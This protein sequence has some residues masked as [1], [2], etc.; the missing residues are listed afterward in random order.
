MLKALRNL[1]NI[2]LLIAAIGILA[3]VFLRHSETVQ[4]TKIPLDH[5]FLRATKRDLVAY[6]LP[7]QATQKPYSSENLATYTRLPDE[8]VIWLEVRPR[9]DGTLVAAFEEREAADAPLFKDVLTEL[10]RSPSRRLI[11]NFRGNR[12]GM[13]QAFAKVVD[14]LRAGDRVLIQS[15]EDGFLKDLR[16]ARP[17]WIYGTSLAQVTRMILFSS[18]GLVSLAQLRGDVLVM[19][20][21]PKEHLL[22]RIEDAII[23]EAHRRKLKIFAGPASTPAEAIQ[24][25]KRGIDG[26]LTTQ[27]EAVLSGRPVE[28][29]AEN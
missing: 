16:E 29:S 9:L 6:R 8:V 19:E 4:E 10:I 18:M 26:A 20:A 17:L 3:W 22:N 12:E 14:E 27:P 2:T 11:L 13:V 5:P 1:I 28:K 15:P 21:P 25:W 24:L 23:H 7:V